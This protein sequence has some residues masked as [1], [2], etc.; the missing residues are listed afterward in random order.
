MG[1]PTF[2]TRML[3][4]ARFVGS[5]GALQDS[6]QGSIL[7]ELPRNAMGNLQKAEL[8]RAAQAAG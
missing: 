1:V 6:P 5:T 2:Y 3:A 8:R 4:D 7:L